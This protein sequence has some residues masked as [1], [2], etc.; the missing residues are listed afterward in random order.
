MLHR[1]EEDARRVRLNF[2]L[3]ASENPLLVGN[4]LGLPKGKLRHARLV[5]LATI[6]LLI[7]SQVGAGDTLLAGAVGEQVIRRASGRTPLPDLSEE[8]LS[9]IDEPDRA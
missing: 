1:F 6:G 9:D 5:T 8:M 7:E 2:Q 3:C 4:L